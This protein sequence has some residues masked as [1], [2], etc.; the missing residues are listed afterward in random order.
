MKMSFD[1]GM[2]DLPPDYFYMVCVKLYW[3]QFLKCQIS[4]F[5]IDK[6]ICIFHVEQYLNNDW[7]FIAK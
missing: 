6:Y 3:I 5:V 4:F 7:V 1:F 2:E